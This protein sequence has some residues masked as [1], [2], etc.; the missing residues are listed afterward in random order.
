VVDLVSVPLKDAIGLFCLLDD[1]LT[2]VLSLFG[3]E[4]QPEAPARGA[5]PSLALRAGDTPI[6]GQRSQLLAL[7]QLALRSARERV[8]HERGPA[9]AEGLVEPALRAYAD[10]L[11]RRN[12]T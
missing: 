11:A 7:E 2:C 9:G 8:R 12:V 10:L 3:D 5:A 1:N 4:R 6:A